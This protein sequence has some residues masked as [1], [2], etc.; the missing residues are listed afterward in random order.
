MKTSVWGWLLLCTLSAATLSF[1]QTASTSLRG[2]VKDPSGA[3]VPGARITLVDKSIGTTL[4]ATSNSAGLYTFAQI[5]PAKYTITATASGFGEQIKTAELLVNQPATIDFTL[6]IQSSTVTVDVSGSAQTLNT[7]DATMG[8]S[9]NNEQIQAMPMD[10]RDP[11]SL[12]SLQPGVLF[13][14]ETISLT[15]KTQASD[16]DSR[17]GA[18]SELARIRAT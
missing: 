15:D 5:T 6:T 8:D 17:Q 12:L 3:L 11:L 1:C 10:G 16:L 18:V 7:T 13:L 9:V 4:S 2:V 14:G